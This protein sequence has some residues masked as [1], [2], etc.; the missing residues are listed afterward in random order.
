VGTNSKIEWTDHTF[1]VVHGC[2]KVDGSP[3]CDGCYAWIWDGRKLYDA[4]THWGASAP[5]LRLSDDYWK[6]PLA[7]NRKAQREGTKFKVFCSSMCDVFESHTTVE[8]ERQKLWPLIEQTPNLIWQLLTK[9]P[10]SIMQMVPK[11]WHGG[12]PE[13]V[14]AM[15]T[16]EN[17]QWFDIRAKHLKTVPA[18]VLGFSCEPLFSAINIG[19]VLTGIDP[20]RI[21][22]I[23]GGESGYKSQCRRSEYAWLTG[24]RDQCVER[25][26]PFFFKQWGNIH[27]DGIYDR[28]KSYR[29][30]DGR[31]WNEFPTSMTKETQE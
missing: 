2:T 7:W 18:K 19:A 15:T 4:V 22:V 12:F 26:I 10:Q 28:D 31:E 6:Q 11:H 21:W 16:A 1:N 13:N 29:L 5:R 3:A 27:E 30:L 24:L 14:W 17:Q 23:A 8:E 9:R 25:R 20:K